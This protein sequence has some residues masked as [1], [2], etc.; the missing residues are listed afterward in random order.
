V[1][2]FVDEKD[3]AGVNILGFVFLWERLPGERVG[4]LGGGGGGV[5][6]NSTLNRPLRLC[7]DT[8]EN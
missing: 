8:L 2:V 3:D 4:E 1:L 6:K 7:N 5:L